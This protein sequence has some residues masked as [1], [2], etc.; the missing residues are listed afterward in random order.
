M[1]FCKFF[2]NLSDRLLFAEPIEQLDYPLNWFSLTFYISKEIVRNRLY[3]H[4]SL[5]FRD[6]SLSLEDLKDSEN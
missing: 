6:K 5:T 2:V 3:E 1:H 4:I